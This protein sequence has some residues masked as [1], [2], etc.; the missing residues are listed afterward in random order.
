LRR[1][2][3]PHLELVDEIERDLRPEGSDP[4]SKETT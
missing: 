3:E 4:R 2:L 1:Y